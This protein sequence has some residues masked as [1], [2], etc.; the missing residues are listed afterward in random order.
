[1]R[2][3]RIAVFRTAVAAALALLAVDAALAAEPSDAVTGDRG[4]ALGDYATAFREWSALADTGDVSA[5]LGVGVL[6]DTGHGAP[7]DFSKALAWYR[8]AAE[9]G[10]ARAAFNVAAMYDN[11]R[12][13]PVDRSEAVRWY[14]KAADQRFGRAAYDLGV[15]L[16]D[17]DGV[18]PD[19][20]AAIRYF[21]M[22]ESD[23]IPAGRESLAALGVL[24]PPP[25]P[26]APRTNP[27]ADRDSSA[28][29]L[30]ERAALAREPPPKNAVAALSYM[31][32]FESE[33]RQGNH[34]AQ[35]NM[36]YA[37]QHGFGETPDQVRAFVDYLHASA[38][39]VPNVRDAALK[40]AAD[41]GR[42]LTPEQHQA[43]RTLLLDDTP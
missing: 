2:A 30:F 11:G 22:A 8:K 19:R 36:G 20:Q 18:P 28:L 9:Q 14:R 4:F 42:S 13:T 27:P 34:L 33:A 10:S 23:G 38:S 6:Y 35:Y 37:L 25:P 16:R 7:Q 43:A 26:A 15:I 39:P 32:V 31:P 40:G 3:R 17:G 41:V 21:R 24:L 29:A 1:M 5:M 12:G